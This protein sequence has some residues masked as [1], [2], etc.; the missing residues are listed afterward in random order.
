MSVV[1][2]GT[3]SSVVAFAG[4]AGGGVYR[5]GASEKGW[6]PAAYGFAA[7]K[8]NT[9][10]W[11]PLE[12][13]II[14][15]GGVGGI[16]KSTDRGTNWSQVWGAS[17]T[18]AQ[19]AI[20][21]VQAGVVYAVGTG[22]WKSIDGGASWS[23]LPLGVTN[24][25]PYSRNLLVSPSDPQVLFCIDTALVVK[26]DDGGQTW[27]G[28]QVK[29]PPR[30]PYNLGGDI[31]FHT[32]KTNT[33]YCTKYGVGVFRSADDG[34]SWVRRPGAGLVEKNVNGLAVSPTKGDTLF[35]A[36]Y[37]GVYRSTDGGASW[38]LAGL[39]GWDVSSISIS[40]EDG[41]LVYARTYTSRRGTRGVFNSVD[42]GNSWRLTSNGLPPKHR[43]IWRIV[44]SPSERDTVLAIS[45]EGGL[46][47]S[48]SGN[49]PGHSP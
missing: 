33:L 9:V 13:Q 2:R 41:R 1:A 38:R 24:P 16:W 8:I 20:D 35:A 19:M 30:L 36:T 23:H 39:D 14:Y 17:D 27:R 29:T 5:Y 3:D 43:D 34:E 21:P 48:S 26:S 11:H 28:V 49:A 22:V 18:I 42:G 10:A 40:Q 45:F 37:D 6:Q 46:Y 44:Q 15:G 7:Q 4:T 12:P 31:A 25:S 47:I 32:T